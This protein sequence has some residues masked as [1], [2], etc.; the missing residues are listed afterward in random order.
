MFKRIFF[1]LLG[2][3]AV[4]P[5][6]HADV[7][8]LVIGT[9]YIEADDPRLALA[10]P[11]VDARM[12]TASLKR[13]AV[14][15]VTLLEEPDA[16]I[17]ESE[18]DLFVNSLAPDDIA[19]LYYAGHGFQ[20]EGHNYFL[21]ADGV[22][23]IPLEDLIRRLTEKA[24]GAIVIVDA[25]RNNPLAA[26]QA[27]STKRSLALNIAGAA[28]SAE[29]ITLYDVANA[30]PGLAQLGN[31]RGL[32]AVVFFSTDPGN[33]AEDGATP[34]KGSPFAT[35]FA[36]QIK[37]RQSLDETFR[38]TAIE[39]NEKTDGRQSPWRQGDL[40]FNVFVGGMRALPIP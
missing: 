5:H 23:L 35:V 1:L 32:S 7:H 30:G 6:A 26:Q 37:R 15:E 10:N 31:L 13:S 25:C 29:S 19:L 14:T 33:V 28:R 12:V 24:R 27:Q 2:I 4:T 3:F 9:D 40:P 21:A 38:K 16:R 34:G 18:F 17:W 20:I 22:S 11:V 39:V 36:Q 8:A